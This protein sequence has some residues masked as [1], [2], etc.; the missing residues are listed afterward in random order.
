MYNKTIFVDLKN[1][2]LTNTICVLSLIDIF[3]VYHKTKF[4]FIRTD[5][6]FLFESSSSYNL[7]DNL[8]SFD[9]VINW[10]FNQENPHHVV[11]GPLLY[12]KELLCLPQH[13]EPLLPP[14]KKTNLN[15]NHTKVIITSYDYSKI[16]RWG[17]QKQWQNII[18]ALRRGNYKISDISENI[19]GLQ[20][21]NSIN[22]LSIYEIANE[23][24]SSHLVIALNNDWAWLAWSY[25]IPVVL[26]SAHTKPHND[27]PSFRPVNKF[28]C[29]GCKNVLLSNSDCPSFLFTFRQNECHTTLSDEQV[30]EQINSALQ[31]DKEKAEEFFEICKNLT[32]NISRD[33]PLVDR[34]SENKSLLVETRRLPHNEFVIKNTIQKLGDGW[35]HIIY[36]HKD[37]YSQIKNICD[38]IS[39]EIEIRILEYSLDRNS[40]NNLMLD[41]NFWKEINCKKVLIYQ[42]DTF[43]FKKLDET[44]LQYD[45]IGAPW[46]VEHSIFI[47]KSKVN[48]PGLIGY[49]GGLSIRT[50]PVMIEILSRYPIPKGIFGDVENLTED[51]YFSWYVKNHYNYPDL[52]V[53]KRFSFESDLEETTFGCH[54][55]WKSNFYEFKKMIYTQIFEES[56][57]PHDF[58]WKFYLNYNKDLIEAGLSSEIQA[59]RHYLFIGRY[60]FR[61]YINFFN[62]IKKLPDNT[63]VKGGGINLFGFGNSSNG[64]GHNMRAFNDALNLTDI[65]FSLTIVDNGTF[66]TDFLRNTGNQ[67][68][69][70]NLFLMNPD[71]EWSDNI[72]LKLHNKYNIALWPWELDKLPEKWKIISSL[73]NEVWAISDFCERVFTKELPHNIIKKVNIPAQWRPK[74]NKQKC[75]QYFGIE[76][77]FVVMFAFDGMSDIVRKNPMITIKAFN[78]SIGKFKDTLLIIKTYNLPKEVELKYLSDLPDNVLIINELW[79]FEETNRLFNATDIYVSLHRSEGSGLSIMEAIDLEIPVVCTN[80][81]GNLDF[82]DEWCQLVDYH[83]VSTEEANLSTYKNCIGA[84]WAEVSLSDAVNKLLQTY[85]NY[86]LYSAKIQSTKKKMK[87]KFNLQNLS[88]FLSKNFN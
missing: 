25:N 79:S 16:K 66:Q 4:V 74:L 19:L 72:T 76:N 60:E 33:F 62:T 88:F 22:H 40:Y 73:F 71:F 10:N 86:E 67:D 83:L 41:I 38:D 65:K 9:I 50:V 68:Y 37:N 45:F 30:V 49:N 44:F 43:I 52:S 2:S 18:D 81:S 27:F 70:T 54:Q 17:T 53:A 48:W 34:N 12:S 29:S 64:L 87:E 51:T 82:C 11:I 46:S 42:T 1:Q 14:M 61:K 84:S 77:K 36:C 24:A 55:P 15:K 8:P 35:G 57:L 21:V 80:Y 31:F 3:T 6:N 59:I 28:S 63:D 13:I 47:E 7:I 56:P 58:D 69:K 5:F 23:I 20:Y 85:D 39:T 75:K 32:E 26:I 78:N